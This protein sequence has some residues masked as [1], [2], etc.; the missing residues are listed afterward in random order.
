MKN[1]ASLFVY[2]KDNRSFSHCQQYFLFRYDTRKEV[3]EP[4]YRQNCNC[5][6]G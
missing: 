2:C 1:N 6:H 3:C 5:V 4:F